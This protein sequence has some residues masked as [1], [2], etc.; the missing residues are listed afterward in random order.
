[1][2]LERCVYTNVQIF[3]YKRNS[4]IILPL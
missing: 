4:S 2:P 3:K 1:M